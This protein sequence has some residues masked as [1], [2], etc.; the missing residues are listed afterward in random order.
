[1]RER[2]FAFWLSRETNVISFEKGIEHLSSRHLALFCLEFYN[3]VTR[4]PKAG[5]VKLEYTF[6]V[7]TFPMQRIRQQ[8]S[9]IFRSYVTAL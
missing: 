3:V 9:N 6:I 8:Q 7:S 5:I 2:S 4:R 1:M